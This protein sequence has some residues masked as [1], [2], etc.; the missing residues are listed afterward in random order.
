[1]TAVIDYAGYFRQML[2]GT[3]I[4]LQL[5]LL[6]FLLSLVIG[7]VLGV[8]RVIPS[9]IVQIFVG[10]YASVM[11][12]V[13]SLLVLFIIFYGG[14][15]VLTAIF[16]SDRGFDLSPFGSG[17]A[18][19]AMVNAAYVADIVHGAIRNLPA[20]QFEACKVLSLPRFQAWR[21]VLLPQVFRL[22]LPGLV[23]IW[24]AVLKETSLVSLVGL[25]DLVAVAKTAGG[26]TRE[27]FL[28]LIVASVF[29]ILVSTL[30]V[31]LADMLERHLNRGYVR[32]R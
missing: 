3:A 24:I 19:I 7:V 31:P 8:L 26:A 20:G 25:Q 11:T 9:R 18:A 15:D 14:S 27:P 5:F 12:G 23:N 21:L 6:G 32:A 13:P 30:T 22:A 29:Y 1:M 2:G 28:Y 17:V 10:A 16:G 4:T